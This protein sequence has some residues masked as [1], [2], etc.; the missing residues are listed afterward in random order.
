[1]RCALDTAR[2]LHWHGTHSLRVFRQLAEAYFSYLIKMLNRPV[3]FFFGEPTYALWISGRS[4]MR[5]TPAY[6]RS[7][8]LYCCLEQHHR[9]S[10]T[11]FLVCT[12]P[13]GNVLQVLDHS[14]NRVEGAHIAGFQ[15]I[16]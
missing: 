9:Q 14:D 6:E 15:Q 4:E 12:D 10:K 7:P 11:P 2:F 13:S 16:E 5:R 1:M 3:R 8:H